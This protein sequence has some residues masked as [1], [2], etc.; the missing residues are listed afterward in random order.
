MTLE[1]GTRFGPYEILA[2]LGVGGIGEVYRARDER[3][4]GDV[5]IKVLPAFFLQD[6]DRMR[7]FKQ[8][9]Q[10]AGGLNH[11]AVAAFGRGDAYSYVRSLADLYVVEGQK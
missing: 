9:A 10:A 7:R 5:A 11:V 4:K 3:L 8:E 1:A 2:P 6:S